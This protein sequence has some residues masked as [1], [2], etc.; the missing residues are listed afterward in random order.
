[1]LCRPSS[2][3]RS[4]RRRFLDPFAIGVGLL[5]VAVGVAAALGA[6]GAAGAELE[7]RARTAE[8]IF[9]EA[10]VRQQVRMESEA[11]SR[12]VDSAVAKAVGS[13]TSSQLAGLGFS[14][15]LSN[16][17]DY[18]G[19]AG[20]RG[21]H[22]Y[23][24]RGADWS[25]LAPHGRLLEGVTRGISD[26]GIAVAR[27]G[28]PILF[29]AVSVRIA[30][31]TFGVIVV[32]EP[33]KRVNLE[34][35]AQPLGLILELRTSRGKAVTSL[36]G[37]D[38][39]PSSVRTFSYPLRLSGASAGTAELRVSLSTVSLARATR[40]AALVAAVVALGVALVLLLLAGSL[41]DRAVVRPL[42]SLQAAIRQVKAGVYDSRLPL[43]GSR[44]LVE[45]ADG[46]NRMAAIV[47]EQQARLEAQ[48]TRDS[49]TGLLN[50][51]CFHEVLEQ[52]TAR[53]TRNGT[54]LAIL[55]IDVDYFKEINDEH[56]HP[57][58][59]RV[60]RAIGACLQDAVRGADVTARLGGDEFALLLPEADA[61]YALVVAERVRA[62]M[63]EI[64]IT[65]T[66]CVSTSVGVA[67]YPS[68]TGD[69]TQLV[70]LADRALYDVKRA[71]RG[72]SRR[73]GRD[74]AAGAAEERAEVLA[75]LGRTEA[76]GVAFQ[77]VVS[78]ADGVIRGYEALA[79]FAQTPGRGPDVWFSQ[80]HR[81]GLG[82][83]L[84][85]RAL[86]AALSCDGL[87]DSAF[88]A[89]NL[90]PTAIMDERIQ[91]A[92]PEDLTNVVV[93]VTEQE[94]V[95][96]IDA[97]VAGLAALR[98]RGARIALDDMGAGYAGFQRMM[99]IEPDVIKLDR[100]LVCGVHEDAQRSALIESLAGFAERT[101][102]VICAEGIENVEELL[103]LARFGI[104]LGQG[105]LLARPG[106]P[107]PQ[108]ADVVVTALG[109][110][111]D[112]RSPSATATPA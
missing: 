104:G 53:A 34:E 19:M 35:I 1:M 56:G 63:G 94:L 23:S 49:L 84:E 103:A 97:L 12:A 80:A 79:R 61:D 26:G 30:A 4:L 57:A 40:S 17:F 29:S 76:V 101:G 47:G 18:V 60:L 89:L 5:C 44:E 108:I 67:C 50:H 24:A 64:P 65:S 106:T 83:E 107:W 36:G 77:P 100:S 69:A 102:A 9:R 95:A 85:I 81:C 70:E 54:P 16:R 11:S 93:E 20:P 22:V 92:L 55:V 42:A 33:I 91:A 88:L 6:R 86:M 27:D 15:T 82:V 28:T 7:N 62:A 110:A 2:V 99:C 78:L 48:A 71:G 98:R 25:L 38:H 96:D 112:A 73:Y 66:T 21:A 90:S 75:L 43:S 74:R 72:G 39:V 8:R 46:F 58:G 51:A 111:R 13:K 41:L 87:P 37:S 109:E 32:G 59:D 68:D 31:P 52:E 10:M 3:S 105:Y 14:N 45:L